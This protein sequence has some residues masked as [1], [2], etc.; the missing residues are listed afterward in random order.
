MTKKNRL[1]ISDITGH[2]EE[3][4]TFDISYRPHT[5]RSETTTPV[6]TD[7]DGCLRLIPGKL[8]T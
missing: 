8:N 1:K 2:D 3:T 7:R 4:E 5:C 6:A